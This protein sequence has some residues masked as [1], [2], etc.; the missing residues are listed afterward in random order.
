MKQLDISYN[1]FKNICVAYS[2]PVFYISD[3]QG[4]YNAYCSSKDFIYNCKIQ[5]LDD[6]TDFEN[7]LK[8]TATSVASQDDAVALVSPIIKE[9]NSANPIVSKGLYVEGKLLTLTGV[10]EGYAEWAFDTMVELQGGDGQVTNGGAV[11]GD[12]VNFGIFHPLYGEIYRFATNVYLF[13]NAIYEISSNLVAQLPAGLAI[14]MT[15]YASDT[16]GRNVICRLRCY[17]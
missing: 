3:V 15:Y 9:A 11:L 1:I 17:K 6:I 10:N 8:S 7:T 16:N 12:Y 13:G 5:S 2:L 4:M 14:R